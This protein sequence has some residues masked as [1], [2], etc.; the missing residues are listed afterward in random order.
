MS[1]E[2]TD[3]DQ[4]EITLAGRGVS[5]GLAF[6]IIQVNTR[7]F[8]APEAY[9]IR[10][11]EIDSEFERFTKAISTTKKQLEQIKRTVK[12]ISGEEESQ[13]FEAHILIL[14][15]SS[16]L[17]KVKNLVR[18][19]LKNVDYCYYTVIQTYIERMRG[20]QDD[21]L[22]ERTTDL[23]DVATRL[24]NNLLLKSNKAQ[25]KEE[26]HILV[27]YDLTPSDTISLDKHKVL[28]FATEQGSY[29]SH[30]AILA[31]SLGLP[32]VVGMEEAVRKVEGF[33]SCILDGTR[34][35]LVIHPSE[36]TFEK[37]YKEYQEYLSL[38][39]ELARECGKKSDTK[40]GHHITLSANVEFPYEV[41][42]L[43]KNGAE[44][45]GL[46]R[47]EFYL[48]ENEGHIPSED[49]QAK[50]YTSVAED[51]A[52]HD[53]IFRTLDSGGDK[54]SGDNLESPEP[55]P[56]LG[57]RGIRFSLA[58]PEIFKVQLRALLRAT[59]SGN[60]GI[61]F[62]M[63]SHIN[64]V[65]LAKELLKECEAE[66]KAEG[67]EISSNYQVGAMIEIPSAALL[68]E[69]IAK[70]VDFFS[71]GTND[72]IQYTTAVDR[73]NPLVSDIYRSADPGVLRLIKMTVEGGNK[74]GIWTGV[75]GEM[76][77]DLELLPILV[78]L[79]IH[80]L[81]VGVHKV[82]MINSALRRLSFK[83]CQAIAEEALHLTRAIEI[84][85][86]SRGI[87]E[88]AY[89][90]LLSMEKKKNK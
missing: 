56:F 7:G 15:D 30:T 10:E 73:I 83:E 65:R 44:G 87:A 89:P 8:F 23:E 39:A 59:P 27:A 41:E 53:A 64:E 52:P 84:R 32:A 24:L 77:S 71:I 76:A 35:L 40:D 63:I 66:L 81:S 37:Y 48:L 86:L 34:G 13:I 11:D 33:A 69:D 17:K 88:K 43:K 16:L 20:A 6:G 80:E 28:G 22:A 47:T 85:V 2:Y 36:N 51:V 3:S 72:L 79:G 78:G 50:L 38:K 26:N 46:Y 75:C 90:E 60:V 21:Y 31:R 42:L 58:K 25:H 82:P 5:S 62:P 67:C 70:E 9:K 4:D 1:W 55:N 54:M 18:E 57:R 19:S 68:A 45:M 12:R 49:E 29:T 74:A 61:M 14:E